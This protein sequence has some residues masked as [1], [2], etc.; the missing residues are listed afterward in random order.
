MKEQIRIIWFSIL[1]VAGSLPVNAQLVIDDIKTISITDRVNWN[2]ESVNSF[3]WE[4][5]FKDS[6]E[7]WYTKQISRAEFES[8]I[9]KTKVD[10]LNL[11][12]QEYR[13]LGLDN[14]KDYMTERN[15]LL[16]KDY[17]LYC[18]T[19]SPYFYKKH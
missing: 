3:V 14:L 6:L 9:N 15:L 10:S 11:L 2:Y 13:K 17:N 4:I 12:F 7:L 19:V 18:D 8:K 5:K 16:E 1:L